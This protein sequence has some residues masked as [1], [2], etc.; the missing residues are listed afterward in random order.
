MDTRLTRLLRVPYPILLG[1]MAF[2]SGAR[3][4]LAVSDAGGFGIVGGGYGDAAWLAREL[5]PIADA[6]RTR[7][8]P[9][10]VGFITWSLAKKPELLDQALAAKPDAVFLSFGDPAPFVDAIKNAGALIICQVQ[11]TAMA[12]DAVAK[13]ADVIVAQGA[14]AG[15]HGLACG[16]LTLAPAVVDAVGH[17][18][19]V[20]LAGGV[21]DGRGLAAAL[22]LGVDGVVVGTRFYASEEALGHPDAKARMVGAATEDT[23]RGIVFDVLRQ[24]LWPG[25]FTIRCIENAQARKWAGREIELMQQLEDEARA[26]AAAHERGDFDVAAV[27]AGEAVGLIHDVPPAR[28][29]VARMVRDASEAIAATARAL[30][31]G[32]ASAPG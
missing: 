3:L 16:S 10:G 23:G 27:V 4:T 2:V 1:P 29:I 5:A 30:G 20:A 14:E 28:E 8:V 32:K 18:V 22:M 13:G 7:A 31:M 9:F 12:R 15:G 11:T 19:P 17:Q 6:R 25:P 26:Y 21:A 24:R